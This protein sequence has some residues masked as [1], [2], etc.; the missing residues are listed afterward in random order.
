MIKMIP[1][2]QNITTLNKILQPTKKNSLINNLSLQWDLRMGPYRAFFSREERYIKICQEIIGRP[3]EDTGLFAIC[4][5]THSGE[6]VACLWLEDAIKMLDYANKRDAFNIASLGKERLSKMITMSDLSYVSTTDISL[7]SQVLISHCF[8]EVLK[9]G[10]QGLLSDCDVGY[11]SMYKRLGMRPIGTLYKATSGRHFI[12]MI[13]HPD[14]D[15]LTLINSPILNILRGINFEPY[16]AICHWYYKLVRDNS[17]LQVG[18]AYYSEAALEFEGHHTITEGLSNEGRETLLKNAMVVNCREG[19]VL[20]AEM[21]GGK[22]FGF[23]QKGVIKVVIGGKTVVLLTQGDIFGEI[24][25][26]LNTKRSAEVIAVSADT[27]VVLFGANAIENLKNEKDKTVIWS[28]LAKV[29][30]QRVVLTN[31]MLG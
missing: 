30:A 31:K 27:E 21:D 3:C 9:I 23:I 17:D 19:E 10:G 4:Q 8:I 29:L 11:F 7:I 2:C 14:E 24:G 15:Y 16:R 1:N 18:S 20:I 28:N 13:F 5:D 22:Y 12:P 26:I 6:I 25:F